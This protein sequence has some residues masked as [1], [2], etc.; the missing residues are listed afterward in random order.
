MKAFIVDVSRCNGCYNCQIA[1]K[2]EH[3]DN[4]WLP[5]AEQEPE[6]GQF[7]CKVEETVHGS[8][9]KVKIEYEPLIC[10]HC[11]NPSCMAAAK[12]GAVYK[13]DDG[14]VI[15]DP[16]KS[17]G[18]KDIV[19]SCPYN[20]IYWNEK[21]EIPQK[22]T[23]CAHLVDDGQPPRCVDACPTDALRFGDEKDFAKEIAEADLTVL[24]TKMGVRVYYINKPKIFVAGTLFDPVE[25]ECVESALVRLIGPDGSAKTCVTDVF[26]DFWFKK[27][28][29]GTYDLVIEADG[30]APYE[31]KGISVTKSTNVG[32]IPLKR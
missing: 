19:D 8:T 17:K 25:N 1:C 18:Q 28:D 10:N 12:D 9:P 7:W 31:K 23:G 27:L 20:R 2:D 3:C 13:R 21:L 15:I 26:G 11:D 4:V 16:V 29:E 22:C 14:L 30:F 32:D 24:D 6:T 5:Y